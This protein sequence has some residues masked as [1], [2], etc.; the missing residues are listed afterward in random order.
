MSG[1][2]GRSGRKKKPS[3]LINEAL[4]RVDQNIVELFEMLIKKALQ[5]DKECLTYL[6]DRR[7]GRP[8][9]SIDQRVKGTLDIS[10]DRI[11]QLIEEARLNDQA[12]VEVEAKVLT[13][14]TD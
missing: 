3:T 10:S 13:D 11:T 8:H 2:P 5:G 6:I 9:Q 4:E 7:M 14:G 12:F 1:K